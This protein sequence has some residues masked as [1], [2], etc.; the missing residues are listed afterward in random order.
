MSTKYP[1]RQFIQDSGIGLS[2]MAIASLLSRQSK[3]TTSDEKAVARSVIFLYMSGGPSQVDTFDPKPALKK[4]A[5]Q[6]VPESIARNV[7]PIKRSGLKNV[8]PSHW[9]FKQ[10]GES[11]IPVSALLPHTA[12]H[13]DDLSLI[14]I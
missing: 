7:P 5:G 4:Y 14:H 11:G 8:M 3:A 12:E 2:S 13:V 9:E 6:D 1:R 10:H